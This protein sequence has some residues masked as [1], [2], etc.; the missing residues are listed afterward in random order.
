MNLETTYLGLRLKNPLIVGA[1]PF[2]DDVY[3]AHKLQ[4]SGAS[5][6]VMRSLFEEQI[7]RGET[8][9]VNSEPA[10]ERLSDPG[11]YFPSSAEYQQSPEQYLYQIEKLR[12]ILTIPVIASLNG[13]RPGPW[14]DFA[15]RCESAGASAIE[16]NL[17]QLP[18]DPTLAADDIESEMLETV[19]KMADAVK[20]PLAVKLS[21]FHTSPAHF[22]TKLEQAGAKGV[23]LFNR[24][25]QPDFD[26]EELAVLPQLKLSDPSELLLRLRWLAILSPVVRGSIA[27]S[28]GVHSAEGIV[29]TLL[30]GA[31]GVQL[32][33]ALLRHGP[34]LLSVLLEGL[35]RWMTAH[36]YKDIEEF[37]GTLNLR[38]CANPAAYERANYQRILQTWRV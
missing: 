31:N 28:G 1:S 14:T 18:A 23:V 5:A 37:R 20:I 8:E 6:I 24:F 29:K 34:H 30:A 32:V 33:S 10:E 4:E 21:P 9:I 25:Y 27:V 7:S 38:R 22:V 16:L 12:A 36:G 26:V 13:C 17:Y 35:R 19:F 11:T 15:T 2:C 3:V